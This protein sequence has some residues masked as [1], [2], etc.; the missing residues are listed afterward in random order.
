V[1]GARAD[2]GGCST[3]VI[4]LRVPGRATMLAMVAI[5][6]DLSCKAPLQE[7]CLFFFDF[8][9]YALS[10]YFEQASLDRKV[11]GCSVISLRK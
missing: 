8:E 6:A 4:L 1:L 11:R 9:R 10:R 7:R 2:R 3:D 5:K